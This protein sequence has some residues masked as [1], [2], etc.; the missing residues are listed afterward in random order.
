MSTAAMIHHTDECHFQYTDGYELFAKRIFRLVQRDI[1]GVPTIDE[2]NPPMITS[3]E[4]TKDIILI[5]ET[6]AIELSINTRAQDFY[7]QS[8]THSQIKRI[9]TQGNKIIFI[10]SKHP[11]YSASISYLG[12]YSGVG[13]F[14]TNQN[15]LELVCFY[16]Y[17]IEGLTDVFQHL[18]KAYPNPT[19]GDLTLDLGDLHDGVTVSVTDV[20]GKLVSTHQFASVETLHINIKGNDGVYFIH[21]LTNDNQSAYL[22][23]IKNKAGQKKLILY[24]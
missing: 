13:K 10:L 11:G 1:Y 15:D 4:L 20:T 19:D 5:V 2:I 16:Q 21:V 8:S 12:Q 22:R 17:P 18:V 14:I 9:R 7:L 3:A 24:N 6:D 23:V